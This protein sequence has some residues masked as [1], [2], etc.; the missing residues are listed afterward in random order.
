MMATAVSFAQEL[1]TVCYNAGFL[2]SEFVSIA[3]E[4]DNRIS[5]DTLSDYYIVAGPLPAFPNLK[6]DVF[7]LTEHF[8][9]NY[10]VTTLTGDEWTILPLT[11][12][13]RFKENQTPDTRFWYLTLGE[14]SQNGSGLVLLDR[15]EN[16]DKI[17]AFTN[18]CLDNL[19]AIIKP[20]R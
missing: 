14:Q 4:I 5:R 17:R 12:I 18:N 15:I 9:Y 16:R 20:S 6:L 19:A 2:E 1:E 10:A 8:V 7:L 11:G 3:T 13:A